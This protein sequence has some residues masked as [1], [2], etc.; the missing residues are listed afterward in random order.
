MSVGLYFNAFSVLGAIFFLDESPLW[1]LRK[2]LYDEA[3]E[4]M[5]KI[6]KWNSTNKVVPVLHYTIESPLLN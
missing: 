4:V 2:G 3:E 6:Y 5:A 1:L